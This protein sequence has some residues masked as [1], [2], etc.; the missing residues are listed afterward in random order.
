MKKYFI[1]AF[2]IGVAIFSSTL[3]G[4]HAC[5][6]AVG[7]L[8]LMSSGLGG[9]YQFISPVTD[10][11]I[12]FNP[13]GMQKKAIQPNTQTD[14]KPFQWTNTRASIVIS[15]VSPHIPAFGMN[16]KGVVIMAHPNFKQG[17]SHE[18]SQG[19]RTY[20]LQMQLAEYILDKASSLDEIPGL[21]SNHAFPAETIPVQFLACKAKSCLAIEFS[22]EGLKTTLSTMKKENHFARM[23]VDSFHTP[24][25]SDDNPNAQSGFGKIISNDGNNRPRP[26]N[27]LFFYAQNGVEHRISWTVEM[28]TSEVG[29]AFLKIYTSSGTSMMEP[30]RPYATFGSFNFPSWG[31]P[32]M[33]SIHDLEKVLRKE[34]HPVLTDLMKPFSPKKARDIRD[35]GIRQW[36]KGVNSENADFYWPDLEAFPSSINRGQLIP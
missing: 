36:N 28:E 24:W 22:R 14:S 9:Q 17:E 12:Y 31:Q 7:W 2:L 27:D 26:V 4:I 30:N 25:R 35:A 6:T 10:G 29:T 8:G 5:R 15:P 1:S 13:V 34:K 33:T 20:L 11:I 16:D 3:S 21:I 23:N 32:K 19:A 18:P